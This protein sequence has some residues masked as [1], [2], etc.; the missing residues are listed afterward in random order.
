MLGSSYEPVFVQYSMTLSLNLVSR[1]TS[2][3][4]GQAQGQKL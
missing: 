3:G 2:A 4:S 1:Q